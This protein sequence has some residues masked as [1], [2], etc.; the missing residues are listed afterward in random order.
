MCIEDRRSTREKAGCLAPKLAFVRLPALTSRSSLLLAGSIAAPAFVGSF[1]VQQSR[2]L[3][4]NPRRHPVSSLALGPQGGQQKGTF[5]ITGTLSLLGAAG[6]A[7]TPSPDRK[8]RAIPA[9]L[10]AAGA[11]LLASGLF[12]TDPVSGYPPGTPETTDPPTPAGVAHDTFSIPVFVGLPL[13]AAISAA[14][15]IQRR[16]LGWAAYSALSAAVTLIAVVRSNGGFAHQRTEWVDS[17]GAWQRV[18][19][20]AGLGWASGHCLQT[21][22]RS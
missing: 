6:L 3:E 12:T 2:R 11:G 1:L 17:A 9:I 5:F 4:Y 13:A 8:S 20:V 22:L 10:G 14:Q 7:R 16:Q 21:L 18:A 15:A 19:I